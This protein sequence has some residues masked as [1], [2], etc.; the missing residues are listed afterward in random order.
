MMFF[1]KEKQET[2]I[3]IDLNKTSNTSIFL[4]KIN[5]VMR[6]NCICTSCC[7][8]RGKSFLNYKIKPFIVIFF[9]LKT[10]NK[11]KYKL[12]SNIET[13]IIDMPIGDYYILIKSLTK[14]Y[15]FKIKL[16]GYEKRLEVLIMEEKVDKKTS[17]H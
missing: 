7:C 6:C 13:I 3:N 16:K 14:K 15:Y 10:K 4:F 1:I 9:N 17:G 12:N 2:E 5:S 8:K 11:F